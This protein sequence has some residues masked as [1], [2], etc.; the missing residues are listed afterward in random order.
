MSTGRPI[1]HLFDDPNLNARIQRRLPSL[2]AR[3]QAQVERG[4]RVGMEAGTLREKVLI[5]LLILKYGRHQVETET[6][7]TEHELDVRVGG[8]GVSIKTTT[9]TKPATRFT[10]KVNWTVDAQTAQAFY[11]NYEPKYDILLATICWENEGGLYVIPVEVQEE[12]MTQL[13]RDKYLEK[14]KQGTNPRGVEL[15]AEAVNQLL[16]HS[17][18]KR[19]SIDWR[20][21][22]EHRERLREQSLNKWIELWQQ[23][24][25][26]ESEA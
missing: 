15:S 10:I 5:A 23:E 3:A 8:Y 18:T 11:E 20:I 22:E 13:G 7:V 25:Q 24:E 1:L 19:L 12:V 9:L 17:E 14:P 21:S 4:G 2:F 26:S 16:K 6:P